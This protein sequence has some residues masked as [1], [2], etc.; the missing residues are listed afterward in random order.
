[1]RRLTPQDWLNRVP[2]EWRGQAF[3]ARTDSVRPCFERLNGIHVAYSL[4]RSYMT[5]YVDEVL[6]GQPRVHSEVRPSS[7]KSDVLYHNSF[8]V[9]Q[10]P[11]VVAVRTLGQPMVVIFDQNAWHETFDLS[12]TPESSKVLCSTIHIRC[13]HRHR[14]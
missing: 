4:M 14:N 10:R 6:K 3:V 8:Q 12:P 7:K 13:E 11:A 5:S 1:M 9:G 2:L